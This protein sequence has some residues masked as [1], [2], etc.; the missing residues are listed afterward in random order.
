MT[1]QLKPCPFCGGHAEISQ[2]GDRSK[3]TIYNCMDCACILETGEAI[4][5]GSRWNTRAQ[6]DK[7]R[8]AVDALKEG[9]GLLSCLLIPAI[10]QGLIKVPTEGMVDYLGSCEKSYKIIDE[11]LA[12]IGVKDG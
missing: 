9:A 4:N 3:S 8:I 2:R 6:D 12:K 1:E 5:H 10:Q 7:L 11:A